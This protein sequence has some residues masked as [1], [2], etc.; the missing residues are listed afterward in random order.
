MPYDASWDCPHKPGEHEFWQESDCLWFYDDSSGAGG[1]YRLGQRPNRST[2]QVTLFAFARDGQRF[3]HVGRQRDPSEHGGKYPIAP[4][5][6]WATGHRVDRF[7]AQYAGA[8]QQRFQWNQPDCAADLM[9]AENFYTP[10]SWPGRAKQWMDNL[11]PEG[12]L[13]V[14]GMLRGDLRIGANTYRIN[15]LAHRDRSWGYR[16][17]SRTQ[18][19]RY[20]MFT[21]TC[22]P[23]MSFA[24]FHMDI[25]GAGLMQAGFVIR[26]GVESEVVDQ[27]V[28]LTL[29]RDGVTTTGSTVILTLKE[30]EKLR[31]RCETVQG[32]LH[33]VPE[34]STPWVA[35]NISKVWYQDLVGFCDMEIGV[36]PGRGRYAPTQDDV[37]LLAVNE[38]LSAAASYEL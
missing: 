8:E 14:G 2:G 34:A 36:N 32:F 18:M 23:A 31:F 15:A 1:F 13:E 19:H 38:G 27:R 3:V 10:R 7:E 37:T 28:L 30:G 24:T 16:D 4:E 22:G 20:R 17:N 29:D 33:P 21:G 9:F 12:H 26:N 25:E 6:R 35:D 5:D 11:N